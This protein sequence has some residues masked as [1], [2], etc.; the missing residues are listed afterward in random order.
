MK[1]LE[2]ELRRIPRERVPGELLASIREIPGRRSPI[3]SDI[4]RIGTLGL[5][6][7]VVYLLSSFASP[8]AELVTEFCLLLAAFTTIGVTVMRRMLVR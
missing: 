4:R 6:G 1:N 2:G 7:L 3:Q 5:A 8:M